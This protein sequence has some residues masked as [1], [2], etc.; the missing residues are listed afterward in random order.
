MYCIYGHIQL[1]AVACFSS[2][3][4]FFLSA[5][6]F[7]YLR[8][9]LETYTS[10]RRLVGLHSKCLLCHKIACI[11]ILL[12]LHI[13]SHSNGSNTQ[14]F[15]VVRQICCRRSSCMQHLFV[16]DNWKR[17][18]VVRKLYLLSHCSWHSCATVTFV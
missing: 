2:F 17:V 4:P 11:S 3:T 13:Y 12:Y 15:V 1:T 8:V 6:T 18:D 14:E 10:T 16:V 5:E 9:A 7:H